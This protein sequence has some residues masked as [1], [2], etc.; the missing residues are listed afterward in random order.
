M[1]K[2]IIEAPG[3]TRQK[4]LAAGA[5]TDWDERH[6]LDGSSGVSVQ[7]GTSGN[8]INQARKSGSN[9][10]ITRGALVYDYRDATLP[11]GIK[12]VR[13]HLFIGGTA[14]SA[15]DT[16]G[17]KIRIGVISNP[18]NAGVVTIAATDYDLARY[19]SNS[20]TSAQTVTNSIGARGGTLQL[21]NKGLLMYLE[22]A[23]NE[24][25]V[26]YLG[27]RNELDFQD[28]ASGVTG[29]NRAWFAPPHAQGGSFHVSTHV[30]LHVFYRIINNQRNIGG[31]GTGRAGKSSFGGT[32]IFA[33]TSCGFN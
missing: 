14:S 24:K 33:G 8:R 30:Q 27:I 18:T 6:A 9:Y 12:V 10:F 13:A 26:L 20:Y 3:D 17:D 32:N 25:D 5:G 11:R 23:I 19:D 16:G 31:G 1:P 21:D 4:P 15:A 7:G 28:D 2:K 29:T 22:R